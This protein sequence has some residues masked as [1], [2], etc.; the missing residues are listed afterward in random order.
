MSID[1]TIGRERDVVGAGRYV[2]NFI[3]AGFIGLGLTYFLRYRG[4]LATWISVAVFIVGVILIAVIA[5]AA[6]SSDLTCFVLDSGERVC[7]QQ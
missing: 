6:Q 5:S 3:L 7:F 4:W 1:T 2:L